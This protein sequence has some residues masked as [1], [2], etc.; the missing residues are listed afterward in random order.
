MSQWPLLSRVRASPTAG[1][2]SCSLERAWISDQEPSCGRSGAPR[3]CKGR[4][5]PRASSNCPRE[6]SPPGF[7]G[8]HK[9]LRPRNEARRA[10]RARW[11][12]AAPAAATVR[13]WL[14]DIGAPLTRVAV[15]TQRAP[16][17]EQVVVQ[18]LRL[19]HTDASVARAL[20]VM[21]WANRDRLRLAD[22]VR[23][24]RRAKEGATLGFF[25]ELTSVLAGSRPFASAYA[26]SEAG[27]APFE[28]LLLRRRR[29]E[30]GREGAGCSQH[31][32]GRSAMAVPDEH[33]PRQLRDPLPK[34]LRC[35]TVL[36]TCAGPSTHT[37]QSTTPAVTPRRS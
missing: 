27:S 35:A 32:T 16:D 25:L 26:D 4:K 21:L 11:S 8:T 17:P 36:S 5:S 3:R 19:A 33:A 23:R 37:T 18:G 7:S 15:A 24:A 22:L 34:D 1:A 9:S 2:L 10:A 28:H 14:R 30:P 6:D 20:P 13:S 29:E 31:A 12:T